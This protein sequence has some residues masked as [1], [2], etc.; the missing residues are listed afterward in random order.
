MPK[1]IKMYCAITKEGKIL[2]DK[3]AQLPAIAKRRNSVEDMDLPINYE[4]AFCYIKVVI[5][6]GSK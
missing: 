3:L 6:H 2:N 5:K 4:I 1:V